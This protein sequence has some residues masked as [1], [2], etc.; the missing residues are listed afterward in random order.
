VTIGNLTIEDR[1]EG[2]S[3][4]ATAH[5][6]QGFIAAG[7][8]SDGSDYS[9][10]LASS[11]Q[12]G[13]HATPQV[14]NEA[15]FDNTDG[16]TVAA[17]SN[18]YW[19]DQFPQQTGPVPFDANGTF[20][21]E[22]DND[23]LAGGTPYNQWVEHEIYFVDGVWTH[24]MNGTPVL[25]V[26]PT[27]AG[28]GTQTATTSGT[29][30]L[31]FLDGF[32]SF[33][34]D[35]QGSQGVFY[36][37]IEVNEVLDAS[38]VPDMTAFL[39][40]GNYIPAVSGL[41]GDLD[42]DGDLD[43]DDLDLLGTFLGSGTTPEE[44]DIDGDGDV[45]VDDISAWLALIGTV[46]GDANFDLQVETGDLAILAGNFN[47]AVS[48][49]AQADFNLDG[50]VD[51]GDLAILAGTFGTD[52]TPALSTAAVPEPATL[53]LIGLGGLAALTRRRQA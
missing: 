13:G 1:N 16:T 30:G 34:L 45:D 9:T 43:V 29:V 41:L 19:L 46:N 37:N 36:D 28:D 35:P 8:A 3:G 32:P 15:A 10:P 20:F 5:I 39:L 6:E 22:N 7:F 50:V 49:F 44:G 53:A 25:Q 31:G 4:L 48:S 23:V 52:N 21:I 14:G 33:N 27:T 42:T 51:T 12:D 2:F 11:N 24:V 47:S 40:A 38:T 18:Q 26:D 17:T